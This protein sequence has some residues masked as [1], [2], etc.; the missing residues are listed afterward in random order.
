MP[1][2]SPVYAA[3]AS[4]A[5]PLFGKKLEPLIGIE[6]LPTHGGYIL[7]ANHVDWLDGFYVSAAVGTT[8]H[9][10][11]N[12]LTGTN[13]YWWTTIAI[14]IPKDRSQLIPFVAKEIQQGKVVCNFPEGQRNTDRQLLPGKTGTVRLAAEAGVPII[15]VGIQCDS[16][17][18]MSQAISNV[19]SNNHRVSIAFGAPISIQIPPGGISSEQLNAETERLMRAIAPLCNKQF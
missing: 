5:Y 10:P 19:F 9:V 18:S 3:L 8:R 16:A 6:N 12:F 13:N 7:A 15:P 14:Q 4:I 2:N 1:T 11:V 17:P